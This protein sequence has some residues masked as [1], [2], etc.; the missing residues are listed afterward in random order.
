MS[1]E[2][3][4]GAEDQAVPTDPQYHH[5][6]KK[7]GSISAKVGRNIRTVMRNRSH[8]SSVSSSTDI[9][10]TSPKRLSVAVQNFSRRGSQ[11]SNSPSQNS[12]SRS[13]AR[14]SPSVPQSDFVRHQPSMSSLSPSLAGQTE[15][16]A[17]SML[18]QHQLQVES[19]PLQLVPRADLHDP[20]IHSE[21]L[22]PFP[23][24]AQLGKKGTGDA[25]PGDKPRLIQQTSDSAVPSQHRVAAEAPAGESIYS[26]PLPLQSPGGSRRASDDSVG[27]RSW[28][29]KAFGQATSPRS[30]GANTV[31]R[32]NSATDVPSIVASRKSSVDGS[33]QSEADPFAGPPAPPPKM[34][35]HRSASP[36]VSVVPEVSEEGSRLTRF[37]AH[38]RLDNASPAIPE[39]DSHAKE[40][41]PKTKEILNRM[42][43]LLSLGP[44]DP[45]RPDIL[46]D[47]P[48]KLLLATQVLQVV[49]VHVSEIL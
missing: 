1:W 45:A 27:K 30:S 46:D 25:A 44:D 12:A 21:K 7:P 32:H 8:S 9:P 19:P 28:L 29:A 17:N 5:K 15:S 39:V 3:V 14:H 24:I 49:N 4:G 26:L 23:G 18:L 13:G 48:R 31:S 16:S 6:R 34:G 10:P 36:S 38:T 22:S 43:D 41:P 33:P 11:S 20:R 42:D 35:R 40:L 47:P 37:T 2:E